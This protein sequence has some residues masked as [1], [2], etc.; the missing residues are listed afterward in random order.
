MTH[1]LAVFFATAV[2]MMARPLRFEGMVDH[3]NR[4][5][6]TDESRK[7]YDRAGLCGRARGAP[8]RRKG[9]VRRNM[10]ACTTQ[11]TMSD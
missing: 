7:A 10:V 2:G 5:Q 8:F 9:I 6:P 3:L 4:V 1:R 11:M